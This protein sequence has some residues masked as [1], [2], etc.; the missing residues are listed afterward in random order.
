[1][2]RRVQICPEVSLRILVSLLAALCVLPTAVPAQNIVGIVVDETDGPIANADVV[3]T[4]SGGA[5]IAGA[6]TDSAG[7]FRLRAGQ[8]GRYVVRVTRPGYLEYESA[9]VDVG[10][11]ETVTVEIRLGTTAIPLEPIVVTARYADPRLTAFHQRRLNRAGAGRFITRSEIE[12]RGRMLTTDILR[13]VPGI[14][15]VTVRARGTVGL[16]ANMVSIRGGGAF[17][18]PTIYIDGMS[19][20]QTPQS[21]LDDILNPATI[22]GIEIYTASSLAPVEY[23]GQGGGCGVLL[24][25]TRSGADAEGSR[26]TLR[27]VLVVIGAAAALFLLVR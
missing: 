12:S 4:D 13:T 7:L 24:F 15:I 8:Q 18:G 22:E 17:C 16:T 3:L 19:V 21:T 11:V 25:W 27:R 26:L 23:S 5:R 2:G 9:P 6:A 14:N 1:M 20:R 10:P